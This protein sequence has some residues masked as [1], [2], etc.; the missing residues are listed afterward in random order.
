MLLRFAVIS[1]GAL[2]FEIISADLL[3]AELLKHALVVYSLLFLLD[4]PILEL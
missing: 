1:Q 2:T 4:H 3:L